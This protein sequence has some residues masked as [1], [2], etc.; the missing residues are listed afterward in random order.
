MSKT[1]KRVL[2]QRTLETAGPLHKALPKA[3]EAEH[4]PAVFGM[5]PGAGDDMAG[6]AI[7]TVQAGKLTVHELAT[8]YARA[9]IADTVKNAAAAFQAMHLGKSFSASAGGQH[10]G[11]MFLV[12]ERGPELQLTFPARR[13]KVGKPAGFDQL[14]DLFLL[15][16]PQMVREINEGPK[17]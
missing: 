13:L 6:V 3:P 4:Q 14:G 9:L 5:D 11:G 15:S 17:K 10:R 16:L 7:G 1:V 12:G 8:A 2:W